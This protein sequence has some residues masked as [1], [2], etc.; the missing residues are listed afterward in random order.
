MR[1]ILPS[2]T[3]RGGMPSSWHSKISEIAELRLSAVA[4]FVTGLDGAQRQLCYA[5]LE[6]LKRTHPF[7]IPFVHAVST[8]PEEEYRYLIERFG[9]EA[10]N[11]HSE[12]EYPL[13]HELSSAVRS[14][15]F[16]ENTRI[17]L[18][19]SARE[20]EGFGGICFDLSHLEDTR[21]NSLARYQ[22][23]LTLARSKKVGA[24]HISA[25]GT[26]LQGKQ[27]NCKLSSRHEARSLA[28]FDY[29]NELDPLAFAQLC[30][31]ELENSLK[32]QIVFLARIRQGLERGEKPALKAA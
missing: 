14:K 26:E 11:L 9:T 16:I 7:T 13:E 21:R 31:I 24:N 23:M 18:A 8:M 30:A 1:R 12:D 32:Q 22:E 2:I 28:D 3:T 27:G 10:F 4:L 17:G 5:E 19:L 25:V 29:L 20:L 15:I 6:K